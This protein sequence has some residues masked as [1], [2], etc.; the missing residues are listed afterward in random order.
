MYSNILNI[1]IPKTL[2]ICILLLKL[3]FNKKSHDS[4][5]WPGHSVH[6]VATK[7]V[8][9]PASPWGMLYG[10]GCCK[11]LCLKF[12]F[13]RR[14]GKPELL[15]LHW[16]TH[17]LG[18]SLDSTQGTPDK[19]TNR[20]SLNA[21]KENFSFE[22]SHRSGNSEKILALTDSPGSRPTRPEPTS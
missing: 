13:A 2:Y 4:M 5:G 15:E 14:R 21:A 7:P 20:T 11:E 10:Q 18:R 12:P 6:S 19:L 8:G 16:A 9:N 1:C 17:P 22:E 3:F